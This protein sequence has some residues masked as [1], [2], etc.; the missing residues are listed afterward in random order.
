VTLRTPF[1]R[2]RWMS[3]MRARQGTPAP[4]AAIDAQ[5]A[6]ANE[7]VEVIVH[8]RSTDARGRDVVDRIRPPVL[9]LASRRRLEPLAI[10]RGQ[11]F[12]GSQMVLGADGQV[13]PEQRWFGTIVFRFRMTAADAGLATLEIVDGAERA[14]L[15]EVDLPRFR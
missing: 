5:A 14:Y 2:A 13:K 4:D 9:T 12:G 8:V 11:P 6:E 10:E 7:A 3:Y 15:I 1:E